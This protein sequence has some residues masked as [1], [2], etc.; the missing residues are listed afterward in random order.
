M[1]K[2]LNKIE[3]VKNKNKPE[4]IKDGQIIIFNNIPI[5]KFRFWKFGILSYSLPPISL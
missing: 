4:N 3:L 5:N 1:P 2:D